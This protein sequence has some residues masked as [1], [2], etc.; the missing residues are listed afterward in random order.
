MDKKNK[1]KNKELDIKR[2]T[3]NRGWVCIMDCGK[4]N[5]GDFISDDEHKKIINTRYFIRSTKCL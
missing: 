4:F 3:S 5:R 1:K 2:N